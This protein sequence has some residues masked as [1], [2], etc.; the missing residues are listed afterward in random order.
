MKAVSKGG[1]RRWQSRF[2]PA[3]SVSSYVSSARCISD[4]IFS[5]ANHIAPALFLLWM[6]FSHS[7]RAMAI[8][9]LRLS[10]SLRVLVLW[11]LLVN[12]CFPSQVVFT[13][14]LCIRQ[15]HH[16]A[17]DSAMPRIHFPNKR[18]NI[19]CRWY[20]SPR[21]PLLCSGTDTVRCV[22]IT[23]APSRKSRPFPTRHNLQ[24]YDSH[25]V[26]PAGWLAGKLP[27]KSVAVVCWRI[28]I[29]TDN[30]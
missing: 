19:A 6:G 7:D 28:M 17:K 4:S 12:S 20:V 26:R 27:F 8:M 10:C 15:Y 5:R 1:G 22:S 23:Y 29:R 18:R 14:M 2:L 9:Y 30:G 16:L 24:L 13:M 3:P 21:W 11:F 25:L